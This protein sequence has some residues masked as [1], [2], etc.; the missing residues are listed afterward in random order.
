M[1]RFIAG[2]S[3]LVR[4][5][6]ARVGQHCRRRHSSTPGWRTVWKTDLAAPSRENSATSWGQAPNYIQFPSQPPSVLRAS[7]RPSPLAAE[8]SDASPVRPS[9]WE[10]VCRRLP[11]DENSQPAI[12]GKLLLL[13]VLR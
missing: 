7:C 5:K 13:L 10:T 9:R 1:E 6:H 4:G 8:P 11:D 12:K 2:R 3:S